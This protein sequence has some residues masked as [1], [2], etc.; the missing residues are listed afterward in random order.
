MVKMH[1]FL[2]DTGYRVTKRVPQWKRIEKLKSLERCRV[3]TTLMKTN[4][5]P[6]PFSKFSIHYAPVLCPYPFLQLVYVYMCVYSNFCIY[7]ANK[8]CR[9]SSTHC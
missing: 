8:L 7:L 2:N 3:D 5:L 1:A 4:N 9:A 6:S